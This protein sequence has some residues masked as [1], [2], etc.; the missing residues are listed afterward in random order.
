MLASGVQI[1]AY[2]IEDQGDGI[3]FNVFCYNVQ[4]GIDINYEDG[5]ST[6]IIDENESSEEIEISQPQEPTESEE[7]EYVSEES[8]NESSSDSQDEP[9]DSE[10][11]TYVLN[12]DSLKFHKPSCHHA[13]KI[14]GKD[15]CEETTKTREE[16]I[17]DG[18]DPCG[19]CDP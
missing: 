14:M 9:S 18:Y 13:K 15:Y 6:L 19:T 3:C 1:E 8:S 12:T 10:K 17:E 2:S 16:V 11:I 5:S 4:P 7:S